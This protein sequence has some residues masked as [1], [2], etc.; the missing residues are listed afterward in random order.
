M[1]RS[2]MLFALVTVAATL[3]D[4]GGTLLIDASAPL[5]LPIS[6]AARGFVLA[7]YSGVLVVAGKFERAPQTFTALGGI[8][9]VFTVLMLALFAVLN[10]VFDRATAGQAIN[11]L[12]LWSVAVQGHII[13][14]A[15]GQHFVVGLMLAFMMFIVLLTLI[16]SMLGSA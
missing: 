6:L 11:L 4:I 2:W 12:L 10:L 1:P 5:I 9:L 13:S 15:L 7:F 16:Q 14:R 3:A 8:D